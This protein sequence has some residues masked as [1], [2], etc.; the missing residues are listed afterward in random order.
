MKYICTAINTINTI[1]KI[2]VMTEKQ[3]RK[4]SK[5][6]ALRS[7]TNCI[8]NLEKLELIEAEEYSQLV[9]IQQKIIERWILRKMQ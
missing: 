1:N 9:D 6:V 2:N 8:I 5:S 4:K 3:E 7:F